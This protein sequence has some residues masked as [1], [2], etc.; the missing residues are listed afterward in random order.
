MISRNGFEAKGLK[1]S[2]NCLRQIFFVPQ[3]SIAMSIVLALH[4]FDSLFPN[5]GPHAEVVV[6]ITAP[7]S[8]VDLKQFMTCSSDSKRLEFSVNC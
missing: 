1:F 5:S 8:D 2:N 7:E 6:I 4:A 3:F